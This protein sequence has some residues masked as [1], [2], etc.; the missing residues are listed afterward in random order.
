MDTIL[1]IQATLGSLINFF[2]EP[3]IV[4]RKRHSI[5][6]VYDFRNSDVPSA[7]A[8]IS[9]NMRQSYD[10]LTEDVYP[11]KTPVVH[12][13]YLECFKRELDL[14]KNLSLN[15]LRECILE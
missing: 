13:D 14:G 7:W 10:S 3:V 11:H 5:K 9:Y 8:E 4:K 2:P 1:R 15:D 12:N 6:L